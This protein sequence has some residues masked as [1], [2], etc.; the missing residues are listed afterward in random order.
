MKAMQAMQEM[1]QKM[2]NAKTPVERNALIADHMKAMQGGMSMVKGS[3]MDGKGSMAGM[4]AMAD[5]KGL[6]AD[7]AKHH[8]SMEQRMAMMQIMMDR[9]PPASLKQ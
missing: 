4:G 3:A 8:K 5:A 7:M 9:L 1:H 2:M 6:P